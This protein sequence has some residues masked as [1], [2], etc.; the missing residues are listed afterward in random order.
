MDHQSVFVQEIVYT[1]TIVCIKISILLLYKG[2]FP[3][4]P[5]R[6]AANLLGLFVVL[7][8]VAVLLVAIFSCIPVQGFWDHTISPPP[9]CINQRNFFIGNSIPNILGDVAILCL[10]VKQVWQLNMSKKTKV[11]VSAMFLLGGL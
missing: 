6:L 3:G 8:G 2:L 4:K 10:P 1:I 11:G 9:K 7:W 5:F